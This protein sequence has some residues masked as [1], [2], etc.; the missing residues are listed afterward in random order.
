M[1]LLGEVAGVIGVF[2]QRTSIQKEVAARLGEIYSKAGFE[3]AYFD[4]AE[5]VPPPYWFTVS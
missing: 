4:G 5:D 3:F 1:G 2:D